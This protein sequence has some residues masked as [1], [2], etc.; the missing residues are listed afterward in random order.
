MNLKL[1]TIKFKTVILRTVSIQNKKKWKINKRGKNEH[2]KYKKWN[3][4]IIAICQWRIRGKAVLEQPNPHYS[5]DYRERNEEEN[6]IRKRRE[7]AIRT[8]KRG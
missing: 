3:L 7:E 1:Y 8:R 6:E 4:W 5:I 2:D